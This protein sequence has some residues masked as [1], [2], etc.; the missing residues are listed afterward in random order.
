MIS[1]GANKKFWL[2]ASS[3]IDIIHK[4]PEM[5]D[6]SESNRLISDKRTEWFDKLTLQW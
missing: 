3:K 1:I 4:N 2:K 5:K 6:F